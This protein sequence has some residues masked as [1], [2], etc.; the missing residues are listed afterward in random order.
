MKLKLPS[1]KFQSPLK[2]LYDEANLPDYK[3]RG[4]NWILRGNLCGAM[5][6]II[7]GGGTTAMVGLATHFGASDLI[8]GILVAIPQIAAL[9]QIPFSLAVNRSHRHKRYLLTWGLFSRVLWLLFGFMTL[10]YPEGSRS[11]IWTLIAVLTVSSICASAIQVSWFPWFSEIAPI[12]IRGRW[13]S[14]R[15]S[16]SSVISIGF[17]LLTAYLLDVLPVS[18]RYIVVFLIGGG[19]GIMDML[20]FSFARDEWSGTQTRSSSSGALKSVFANKQFMRLTIAWTAWNFTCNMAGS[21][22]TPYS[23]N[24]MGL[25]YMQMMLCATIAAAAAT[26]F[27]VRRWGRAVDAFGSKTVMTITC[28]GSSLALIF[29]L[30]S[31]P[32]SV[33]PVLLRNLVG[34]AF[35]S[36]TG[37]AT[38]SMQ[39]SYSPEENRSTYIAVFSCVT[40]LAGTALGTLCGGWFL[41]FCADNGLLTGAFDRYK[42]LIL[43][44]CVLRIASMMILIPGLRND[45][46]GSVSVKDALKSVFGVHF[47]RVQRVR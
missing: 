47:R 8:F 4:L 21:Y 14:F 35:W 11:A 20:S 6:A 12:S 32:G 24:R 18:S 22:L 40:A 13:F 5:C 31:T 34:A 45:H 10:I 27:M 36:G 25:S 3:R 23:M 44:S 26:V 16:L 15:D 37:L 29:Y 33:W 39:L 19:V 41:D 28:V 30:F 7:C 1:I 2:H 38:N 46:E 17:G 9:F 42:V 43:A